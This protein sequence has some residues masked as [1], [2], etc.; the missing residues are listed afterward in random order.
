MI[1]KIFLLIL[2]PLTFIS[3]FP[4]WSSPVDI[5]PYSMAYFQPNAA[6]TLAADTLGN[7]HIT[8]YDASKDAYNCIKKTKYDGTDWL[9]TSSFLDDPPGGTGY[10]ALSWMPTISVEPD[11]KS[12]VVWEDYRTGSFELYSKYFN[13]SL[14]SSQITVTNTFNSYTW[15]PKLCYGNK[16]H[17]LVF[18][19]DSTGYF[20]IYYT[21]FDTIFQQKVNITPLENN[22]ISPDI[23]AY[24]DGEVS[25]IYSTETD[26]YQVLYNVRNTGSGWSSPLIVADPAA[27]AYCPN[28]IS[29]GADEYAIFTA[30][31]SGVTDLFVSKFNGFSW[32]V[33]VLLSDTRSNIS[34]PA[35]I[36]TGGKLRLVYV[37]DENQYGNLYTILYN[38]FT[39]VIEEK[40]LLA[41]HLH[42]YIVLP[43]IIEDANGNIHVVYIVNDDTPVNENQTNDIWWTKLPPAKKEIAQKEKP[44]KASLTYKGCLLTFKDE[45]MYRV[46]MVDK[47]GRKLFERENVNNEI[48]ISKDLMQRNDIY[49]LLIESGE[50]K[51]GEKILWIR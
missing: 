36:M 12:L 40:T 27:N 29:N 26:G 18:M 33:E 4:Q 17:H 13:N 46:S 16:K 39:G 23:F 22:C 42:G 6:H 11:G 43:Q 34:H 31:I 30:N 21:Y 28:L 45:N 49:F 25:V 5:W 35:G 1:K 51:Y 3:V 50:S 2:F 32:G 7:V 47:L 48:V 19:D 14:W 37:S 41:S 10:Y 20:N 38:P 15:F 44:Y 8:W 9:Y 24:Q